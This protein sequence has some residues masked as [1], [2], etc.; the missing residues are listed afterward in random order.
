MTD[1]TN[2]V[3]V[4]GSD[5]RSF[6]TVI[7]SLGR[8]GKDVHVAW[9]ARTSLAK[10]SKYVARVHEVVR[11]PASNWT[12]EFLELLRNEQFDL[13][14]PCNDPSILPLH[15]QRDLFS[16][17]PICLVKEQTFDIVMDKVAVNEIAAKAGMRLPKE[18]VLRSMNEVEEFQVLRPPYA[19]KP[20]Q[21]YTARHLAQK[22][23]VAI[24]ADYQTASIQVAKMLERTPVAVQEYFS[25]QG[26]GVE[27]LAKEG[28]ILTAFQHLRLHEP[29]KGGGSSYR[30]SC[31]LNPELLAE[32][33]SLVESL[34]YTGVGMAEFRYNFQ[35]NDWIF[36]ELN[37]RFWGSLPL[38][39][40]C[41]VDF[42]LFLYEMHCQ[43]RQSFPDHY[44]LNTACRNWMMDLQWLQETLATNGT[45]LRRQFGLVWQ[46]FKELRFPL[47]LRESCDTITRDDRSPGVNEIREAIQEIPQKFR[48]KTFRNK[49]NSLAYRQRTQSQVDQIMK[50]ASHVLFVCK[51]NICRSPFA[52]QYARAKMPHLARI[53]SCGY[54]PIS[55]RPSPKNAVLAAADFDVDLS[56]H[57]SAV[58]SP[59]AVQQAEIIFVFDFENFHTVQKQFR[60]AKAKTFL[61][62]SAEESLPTELVDPYGGTLDDFRAIYT[63]IASAVDS[64]AT[65]CEAT[66]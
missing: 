9:C 30:K 10:T 54:Y 32:T 48:R 55:D 42:P 25:G 6:L 2:K 66:S 51:G 64:L 4:L 36:V 14:V 47:M 45:N 44:R 31:S 17:Y 46:L 21:S 20:T 56:P 13:I 39:V 8:A 15:E 22:N 60:Q 26:V 29:L 49:A 52:E 59:K 18:V 16:S 53:D 34:N 38:A 40:A 65:F 57:S 11:P 63:E 23:H 33:T 3:L 1:L 24:V 27:F 35:S 7:R 28:K 12:T 41:G 61:L 5:M 50:D 58:I 37:S 43:N 19:L 62:S